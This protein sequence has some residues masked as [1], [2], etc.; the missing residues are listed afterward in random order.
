MTKIS[1]RVCAFCTSRIPHDHLTCREHWQFYLDNRTEQWVVEL[2]E[3][4]RRQFVIDTE[5]EI[6]R[7]GIVPQQ[8]RKNGRLSADDIQRIEFYFQRGISY[9]NIS[10]IIGAN[11]HTISYYIRRKLRKTPH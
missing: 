8:K 11:K 9:T 6:L 7:T 3:A 1:S 4:E 10:K 5:E 2:V